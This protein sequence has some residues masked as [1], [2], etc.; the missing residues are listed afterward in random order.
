[1]L[2]C[3]LTA[4]GK[5][6]AKQE[7]CLHVKQCEV[8]TYP[9]PNF[10]GGPIKLQVRVWM[11]NMIPRKVMYVITYLCPNLRK[12]MMKIKQI[13]WLIILIFLSNNKQKLYVR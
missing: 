13:H 4:S 12:T 5:I 2:F 8:I 9:Y 7:Y 11:S 10:N 1:M 6:I 3:M